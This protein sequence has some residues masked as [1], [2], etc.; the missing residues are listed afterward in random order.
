MEEWR[1]LHCDMNDLGQWL[2]DTERLLSESVG[3]DGRLE[4]ESARQR[5]EVSRAVGG[6]GWGGGCLCCVGWLTTLIMISEADPLCRH[7]EWM[8]SIENSSVADIPRLLIIMF[9]FPCG[10]EGEKKILLLRN[11]KTTT[12]TKKLRK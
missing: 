1:Q 7:G 9:F 10:R 6:G 12:T 4:L 5:Q 8:C 11:R 3:P 2:S